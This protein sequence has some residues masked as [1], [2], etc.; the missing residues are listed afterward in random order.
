MQTLFRC[1]SVEAVEPQLHRK[2]KQ[3]MHAGISDRLLVFPLRA[4]EK[5]SQPPT[6]RSTRQKTHK[7]ALQI[8]S[9]LLQDDW[10]TISVRK[11]LVAHAD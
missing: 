3:Q 6:F 8:R 7:T 9:N 2:G 1:A 4:S 10:W 11:R 5:G